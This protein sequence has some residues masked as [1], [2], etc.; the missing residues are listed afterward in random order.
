MALSPSQNPIPWVAAP[1]RKLTWRTW[2]EA[3]TVVYDPGSGD[4]HVLDP[5]SALVLERLEHQP[6][7]R[8]ALFEEVGREL[9][10][11]VD[12]TL[13]GHVDK[14]LED[15]DDLGLIAQGEA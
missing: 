12:A 13:R 7:T 9:G 14:T 2:D 15:F 4:T 10:V 8:D 11:D 5:I 1:D 3:E 6:M